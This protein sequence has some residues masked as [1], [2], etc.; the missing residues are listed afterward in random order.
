[1]ARR[2]VPILIA[3]SLAALTVRAGVPEGLWVA[4]G[5][6][7]Y[8]LEPGESVQ[9][10]VEFDDIPLRAWILTVEG[11]QRLCDLNVLRLGNNQLVYQKHDESRHSV[12]IPWGTGE[13]VA[14]TVTAD[15]SVG[16][17]FT[18]K[19]LGPPADQA[20]RAY[21]DKINRALE[22]LE[23]GSDSGAEV[24]LRDV[25]REDGDEVGLAALLL[26]GL[27]KD[28]GELDRAVAMLDLAL[29]YELPEG[30]AEVE[31]RLHA[32]L[33]AATRS[34]PPELREADRLLAAGDPDAVVAHC[35]RWL[36]SLAQDES[37]AWER[38]E[39][40]RRIGRAHQ[41]RGRQVRAM[42]ALNSALREA[43]EPGQKA[44]VFHRLG[45]LL[46]DMGNADQA[47]R[48]LEAAREL[49]LPPDLNANAEDLLSLFNE[50]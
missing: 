6:E 7:T 17:L 25:I 1:M 15:T 8:N 48:A 16:G 32:H 45:L 3:L 43:R 34:V 35:E 13:A 22:H 12:R 23:A 2:G 31:K 18:I 9:F 30:F 29:H 36:E 41:E 46:L 4:W 47:R 21:G 44:L 10:R 14:V 49:G 37:R 27:L 28:R 26:A 39:A 50:E 33:A 20:E 42:E 38:C 5:T 11:D 19:F 40:L 24:L